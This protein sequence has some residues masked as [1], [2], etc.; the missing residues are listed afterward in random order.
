MRTSILI[1]LIIFSSCGKIDENSLLSEAES[2]SKFTLTKTSKNY[3]DKDSLWHTEK[4]ERDYD[5]KNRVISANDISFYFYNPNNKIA[6]TKYINRRA[7]ATSIIQEDYIYDSR[8]N[9]VA[10]VRNDNSAG[11]DTLK[12]YKYDL[13]NNLIYE[14]NEYWQKKYKYSGN[15]LIEK[16]EI[17]NGKVGKISKYEYYQDG[18]VKTEDWLFGDRNKMRTYFTYYSN[19]K[20]FSE[21][22]SSFKKTNIPNEF[23]EFKTEYYYLKNDSLCRKKHLGRVFSEKEFKLRGYE[24]YQYKKRNGL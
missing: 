23:V 16:L 6:K 13:S 18:K 10:V 8:G 15:R 5:S 14:G 20:L 4:L 12:H 1:L 9:L 19:G 7:R 11:Q 2:N 17:E 24:T 22:D 21:R 3:T